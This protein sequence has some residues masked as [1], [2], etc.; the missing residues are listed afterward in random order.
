MKIIKK[1]VK[2]FKK[3]QKTETKKL[4]D[5]FSV[6]C[7]NSANYQNYPDITFSGANLFPQAL[8]EFS[9]SIGYHADESLVSLSEYSEETQLSK[10]FDA[11]GSDKGWHGYSRIYVDILKRLAEKTP[12]IRL[13]EI[14]LGSNDPEMISS[15][16]AQGK[17]G[18]SLRAFA[19]YMPHAACFGAD[20]DQKALFRE[21]R[22]ETAFVDQLDPAS[23]ETMFATFGGQDFD[24]VIDDGLHAP[25]ANINTLMF[26]LKHIRQDGWV[27]IEDIPERTLPV[28]RLCAGLLRAKNMPIRIVKANHAHMV[29]VGPVQHSS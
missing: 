22:I 12:H 17:P 20:L 5:K 4:I 19:E 26:G 10:I 9:K 1:L 28:W 13:L 15:M 7:P 14:G 18:A 27:V 3:S 8:Q 21:E 23:F 29:V 25:I 24:L 16:G 2:N 11:Y 6:F